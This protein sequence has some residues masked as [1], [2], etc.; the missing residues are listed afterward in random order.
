[1]LTVAAFPRGQGTAA[2]CCPVAVYKEGIPGFCLCH[3]N[4]NIQIK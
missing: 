4:K 1:M 3:R 2:C